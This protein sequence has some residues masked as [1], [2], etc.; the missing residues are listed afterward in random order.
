MTF[1]PTDF[2][3]PDTSKYMK[4]SE[5]ANKFR[6]LDDAVIGVEYWTKE[7][8]KK[9]PHRVEPGT[10]IP[11]REVAI[12]QYG[13]K[14]VAFFI[15]FPVWNYKS[16]TVQILVV[17]QKGVMESINNLAQ[18]MEWGD[19]QDYDIT[20]TQVKENGKIKYPSTTPSPKKPL[21]SQQKEA[22]KNTP[23]NMEAWMEGKD[24]F[25]E[26]IDPDEVKI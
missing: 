6:A 11:M 10:N 2:K 22:F 17:K 12:N 7:G 5:G 1:L 21:T 8:E 3:V 25:G 4:F 15:A 19:P 23:V 18:D 14:S 13:N 16:E 20:V 24:P 26:D 9:I